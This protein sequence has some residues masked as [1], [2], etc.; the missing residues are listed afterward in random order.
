MTE[1]QSVI[2][3]NPSRQTDAVLR[4]TSVLTRPVMTASV[5]ILLL[6][7]L[8]RTLY[9]GSQ[10]FS[11]DEIDR[12]YLARFPLDASLRGIALEGLH[13][14][15]LLF[16]MLRPF[17]NPLSETLARIPMV[18]CGVITVAIMAALAQKWLGQWAGIAALWLFALNPFLIWFSRL[19]TM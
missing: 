10:S 1:S 3:S 6:A 14:S 5:A 19:S 12:V 8:A 9:L 4:S 16:L 11:F 7:T 18:L 17:V 2:P 15:P 13:S